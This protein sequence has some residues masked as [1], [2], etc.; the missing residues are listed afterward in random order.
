[1]LNRLKIPKELRK[2]IDKELE[3]TEEYIK[4]IEQP[5]PRFFTKQSFIFFRYGILGAV[6][7]RLLVKDLLEDLNSLSFQE[8]LQFK[9]AKAFS[10]TAL[11]NI[12]LAIIKCLSSV[13]PFLTSKSQLRQ[14]IDYKF[15]KFSPDKTLDYEAA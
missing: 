7:A 8:G 6:I 12:V 9:K 14:P 3:T 11:V 1:M 10:T 4:W 15:S 13:D 5:K 2:I